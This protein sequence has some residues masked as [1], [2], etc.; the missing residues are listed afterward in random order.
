MQL[1][2]KKRRSAASDLE[3]QQLETRPL[4]SG[5]KKRKPLV[6]SY[7]LI[8]RLAD[9]AAGAAPDSGRNAVSPAACREREQHLKNKSSRQPKCLPSQISLKFLNH[10]SKILGH[11][12]VDV[13]LLEVDVIADFIKAVEQWLLSSKIQPQ[14]GPHRGGVAGWLNDKG[15]PVFLYPE[16]TG[17]F[18]TWLTFLSE[19]N[20]DSE[21]VAERAGMAIDWVARHYDGT[22]A[23]DTRVYL[24]PCREADWRNSGIFAFDLAMLA[25]GTAAARS[26]LDTEQ[27]RSTLARLVELLVPFCSEGTALVAFKPA[28][29]EAAPIHSGKWSVNCGPYQSKVAVAIL[30]ANTYA[31]LPGSLHSTAASSYSQWR[32]HSIR[33]EIHAEPHPAFYHMEGLAIAAI[34]GWDPEVWRILAD[35]YLQA[36]GLKNPAARYAR[37]FN[38]AA[39]ENRSDVLAQALRMGCIIRSRN[40]DESAELDEKLEHLYSTLCGFAAQDGALFFSKSEPRHKNVWSALFAHQALSYYEAVSAGRPIPDRW[41]QLLV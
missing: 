6:S 18:L 7:I 5:N 2:H 41:I 23:P 33:N 30:S 21:M 28:D 8:C 16:I 19:K 4:F 14:S 20:R 3:K 38:G 15:S 25:R 39:S 34:N 26:L 12:H 35:A 13:S 11:P 10:S 27:R 9:K 22:K 36:V 31:E 17:Y 32:T 24:E 40:L 37:F 29:R 1:F